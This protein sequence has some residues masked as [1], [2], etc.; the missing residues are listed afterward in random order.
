MCGHY[1]VTYTVHKKN[2]KNRIIKYHRNLRVQK[3]QSHNFLTAQQY[4]TLW[5]SEQQSQLQRVCQHCTIA[6]SNLENDT[7]FQDCETMSCH[8]EIVHIFQFIQNTYMPLGKVAY[9]TTLMAT[10]MS[11]FHTFK[12]SSLYLKAKMLVTPPRPPWPCPSCSQR[13]GLQAK[14]LIC[15]HTMIYPTRSTEGRGWNNHISST[16]KTIHNTHSVMSTGTAMARV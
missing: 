2:K 5:T 10:G 11:D 8:L 4:D 7:R 12:K 9:E 3:Y 13:S 14:F 6:W 15:W 1:Q 16:K